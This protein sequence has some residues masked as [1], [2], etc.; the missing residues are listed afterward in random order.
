MATFEQLFVDVERLTASVPKAASGVTAIAK[1][2]IKAA[3][4]GDPG[5]VRRSL[6]RLVGA[7]QAVHGAATAAKGAWSLSEEDEEQYLGGGYEGELKGALSAAGF[8]AFPS[9]DELMAFPFVLK[10]V[11]KERALR[12]TGKKTTILRPSSVVA[13]LE[14]S[15]KP[16]HTNERLVEAFFEAYRVLVGPNLGRAVTLRRIYEVLT[17]LPGADSHYPEAEFIRDVFAIDRHGPRTTKA[18][19][20]LS[21]VGSTGTKIKRDVLAF[22]GPEGELVEYYGI[23]FSERT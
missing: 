18:G 6:E 12:I 21:L 15:K 10:V 5:E 8:P 14:R 2:V 1:Q 9:G 19:H 16:K 4:A 11:P 17:L 20:A 7:A 23:T 3:K 13:L 22:V